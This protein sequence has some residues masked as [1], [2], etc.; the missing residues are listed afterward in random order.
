MRFGIQRRRGRGSRGGSN[1]RL[2][3]D[4]R[5]G[6]GHARG[7]RRVW[8]QIIMQP[9][10]GNKVRTLLPDLGKMFLLRK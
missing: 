9:V 6:R 5:R 3:R 10:L 7:Q 4:V 8:R 1:P 2:A